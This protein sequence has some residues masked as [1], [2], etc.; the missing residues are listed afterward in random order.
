[1]AHVPGSSY[2]VRSAG[3]ENRSWVGLIQRRYHLFDWGWPFR[4][5][6]PESSIRSRIRYAPRIQKRT[7][8]SLGRLQARP[9]WVCEEGGCA[10]WR[11]CRGVLRWRRVQA[12]QLCVAGAA[13]GEE[14]WEGGNSGRDASTLESQTWLCKAGVNELCL[15][16]DGLRIRRLCWNPYH[17]LRWFQLATFFC[18]GELYVRVAW[19]KS[20]MPG[21][22]EKTSALVRHR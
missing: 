7:R 5:F 8:L 18:S 21:C 20:D 6:L 10:T 12:G 19:Q 11:S 13:E 22:C 14:E 17:F 2:K 15:A 16:S 4:W 9:V 3:A 1:M